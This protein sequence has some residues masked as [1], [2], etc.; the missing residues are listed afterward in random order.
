MKNFSFK[1]IFSLS[2]ES[3]IKGATIL[4]LAFLVSK[5]F[6]LLRNRLLAGYF[7]AGDILD[8]YY[9]AFRLP[10]FLFNLIILGAVS[11][12]FIPLFSEVIETKKEKP[13]EKWDFVNNLLNV[14]LLI[15]LVLIFCF[16]LFA[17]QIMALI[18]PGFALEKLLLVIKFSQIMMFGTIFF[19]LSSIFSGILQTYRRFLA[20]SLAPI[21]YNLGIIF[22]IIFLTPLFGP[23]GLALGV[24]LGA[25]A[26]AFSQFWSVKNLGY[27]FRLGFINLKD[28]LLKRM[29]YLS[30][31]RAL[32]LAINQINFLAITI[33]GSRLATGSLAVF[34]LANDLQ[35]LP[36]SLFSLSLATAAFPIFSQ[37]VAARKIEN[38]KENFRTSISLTLF[39]T[40]P[41][42]I[43]F[44]LL[45]AQIVRLVLG[46]GKF[47]WED[48]IATADALAFFSLSLF[49]QALIPLLTRAF[50]AFQ[51]TLKPFL[52]SLCALGINIFL[53]IWG[54]QRLQVAGLALAFSGAALGQLILLW[55]VLRF[56][57][58]SLGEEKLLP[59]LYKLSAVVL[60]MTPAVQLTKN[61]LGNLVDM[62]TFLGVFW[63]FLGA[64]LV[65]L[66]IYF[67]GAY[68]LKEENAL[69]LKNLFQRKFFKKKN[70]L[71]QTPPIQNDNPDF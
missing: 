13:E 57:I 35:S 33:I 19:G 65:G 71:T 46:W 67:L 18:T 70:I 29:F 10:D 52:I 24:V 41:I 62:H 40:I 21:F 2:T 20:Y 61:F 27:R 45:R 34:N 23:I 5:I 26:H 31:P 56:K 38:F 11:A 58:G 43:L 28:E 7:G 47:D 37:A 4:A 9:A 59:S 49:A 1:K 14:F 16:I 42:M 30:V 32:S 12:G 63:Q 25:F 68:I 48:T 50:Y 17:R 6:G 55:V 39:L 69:F 22:G 36:L 64:S 51:D 8:A 3:L 54:S 44:L 15:L 53:A 66:G 60:I